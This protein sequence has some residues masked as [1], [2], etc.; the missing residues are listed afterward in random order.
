MLELVGPETRNTTKRGGVGGWE[1]LTDNLPSSFGI[2]STNFDKKSQNDSQFV[3][4]RADFN[5]MISK[6][7]DSSRQLL[8]Q[9]M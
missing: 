6:F 2:I 7:I 5:I 3:H 4:N 8:I 9:R 1:Y